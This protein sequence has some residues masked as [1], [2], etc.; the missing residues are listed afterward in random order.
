[1]TYRALYIEALEAMLQV[2]GKEA[3]MNK[4][5]DEYDSPTTEGLRVWVTDR[6][7]ACGTC[8]RSFLVSKEVGLD[9]EVVCQEH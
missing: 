7:V 6:E 2:G 1:M 8:G 3:S 5:F 4:I 9:V